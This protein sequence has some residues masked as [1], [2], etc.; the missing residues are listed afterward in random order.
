MKAIA[1][2]YSW[3]GLLNVCLLQWLFV[4]LEGEVNSSG[5]VLAFNVIGPIVPL[6]GWTFGYVPQHFGRL[7]VWARS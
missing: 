2:G 1:F 7:R 6:T 3:L 4:R 5:V